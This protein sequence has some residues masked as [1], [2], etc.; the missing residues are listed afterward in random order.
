MTIHTDDLN[1]TDKIKE[2][3]VNYGIEEALIESTFVDIIV[4][5]HLGPKSGGIIAVWRE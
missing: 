4:G 1:I 2:E 3:L 5:N